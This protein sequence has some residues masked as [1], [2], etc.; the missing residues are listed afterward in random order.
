MGTNDRKDQHDN[1]R[2][3]IMQSAYTLFGQVGYTKA[4]MKEIAANAGVA[5]GLIGYHFGTKETLLVEVVREW[6]INRGMRDAFAT[7]DLNSPPEQLL[8]NSLAHIVKFRK[9]NPEW[10]TLLISLWYESRNNEALA[11]HLADLYQEMKNGIIQV[12]DYILVNIQLDQEKKK[13]FASITQAVFDGLTLQGT[14]ENNP[15]PL[16]F[17]ALSVGIEL[18]IQG[19]LHSNNESWSK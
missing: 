4:T 18:L 5:Q 8:Q 19:L 16:S 13:I 2:E 15:E 14:S 9:E 12:L 7:I 6:M 17:E 11:K 3:A 10:F 1:R